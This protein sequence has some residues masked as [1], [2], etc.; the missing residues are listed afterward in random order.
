MQVNPN[1]NVGAVARVNGQPPAPA[2]AKSANNDVSLKETQAL[3]AAVSQT[4]E[5]RSAE[6]ARA[7]HL[8]G[9][10]DYPPDAIMNGLAKLLALHAGRSE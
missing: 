6:V 8:V 10:Q 5:V 7:V 3:N 9:D 2:K 4:P 1:S